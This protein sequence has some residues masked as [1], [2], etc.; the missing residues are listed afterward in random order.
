MKRTEFL[1]QMLQID[2]IRDAARAPPLHVEHIFGRGFFYEER[3]PG[4]CRGER[5]WSPDNPMKR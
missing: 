2:R 5:V 1:Q 3:F 4:S